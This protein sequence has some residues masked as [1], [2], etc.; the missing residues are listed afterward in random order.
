MS[1][2]V[3]LD[4]YRDSVRDI[5]IEDSF[6]NV[7]TA[8]IVVWEDNRY[9]AFHEPGSY[10]TLFGSEWDIS[11]HDWSRGEEAGSYHYTLHCFPRGFSEII[12]A[13]YATFEE[14]YSS[15]KGSPEHFKPEEPKNWDFPEDPFT[16]PIP[17]FNTT[18]GALMQKY[19]LQSWE[20][21]IEQPGEAIWL[22]Y[23]HKGLRC[24]RL[25]NMLSFETISF[26]DL[27]DKDEDGEPLLDLH[28]SYAFKHGTPNVIFQAEVFPIPFDY[29]GLYQYMMDYHWEV[30][31]SVPF[32]I[33][34]LYQ[35]E[36]RDDKR[37]TDL[38]AL[39]CV[40]ASAHINPNAG[41]TPFTGLFTHL[42][43]GTKDSLGDQDWGSIGLPVSYSGKGVTA[44]KGQLAGELIIKGV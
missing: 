39:T 29:V 2:H 24:H 34:G 27:V 17:C 7:A 20:V 8:V 19:R 40:S 23:S 12:T 37:F 9:W 43:F 6:M 1:V 36:Q 22:Y 38:P 31:S 44:H 5:R 35:F 11:V 25:N 10:I 3:N 13:P 32:L 28:V 15:L 14:L 26:S 30:H 33:G 21:N 4:E 18:F 42:N 16:V 41:L